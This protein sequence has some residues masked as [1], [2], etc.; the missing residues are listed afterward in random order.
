MPTKAASCATTSRIFAAS[1]A[2]TVSAS[3]I[4][5]IAALVEPRLE[6]ALRGD[7][8]ALGTTPPAALP[9]IERRLRELGRPAL[10]H[11]RD[12]QTEPRRQRRDERVGLRGH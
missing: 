1:A 7:L 5:L 2:S 11:R 8:V 4:A 10:V 3:G 9:R 12:G 6:D